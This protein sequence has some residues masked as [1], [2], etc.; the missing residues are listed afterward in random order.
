MDRSTCKKI[1]TLKKDFCDI[2][3]RNGGLSKLT[4]FNLEKLTLRTGLI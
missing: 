3:D 1:M 4:M 2:L